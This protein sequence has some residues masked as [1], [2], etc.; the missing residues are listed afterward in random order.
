M[1]G[2]GLELGPFLKYIRHKHIRQTDIQRAHNK[3][4]AEIEPGIATEARRGCQSSVLEGVTLTSGL[5]AGMGPESGISPAHI[6]SEGWIG[7]NTYTLIVIDGV[8]ITLSHSLISCKLGS[9]YG[10]ALHFN[11]IIW[12]VY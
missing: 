6:S 4:N 8:T 7:E 3:H 1:L 10:I 5:Q 12:A 11:A 2:K 9:L